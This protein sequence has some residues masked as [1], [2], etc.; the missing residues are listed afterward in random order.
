MKPVFVLGTGRCG[1]TLVHEVLVRHPEIGFISNLDDNLRMLNLKGRW[2]GP[3]YRRI[4]PRLTQKGRPRFA[5]SEGYRLL[6]RHVAP[7]FAHAFRD[8]HAED[9]TPWLARRFREFFEERAR[10][11]GTP[12]FLHKFTGWPRSGFI[13]EILPGAR[14][15]HVVRDG[16]AVVNSYLQ[17]PWWL[18]YRGPWAWQIGPLPDAYAAEWEEAGRSFVLL[19]ALGWKIFMDAFERARARVPAGDWL[20][21]RFEDFLADP[22]AHARQMLDFMGLEWT[23]A[24]ETG[25]LRFSF[26]RSRGLAYRDELGARQLQLVE[27][28]L[29]GHL[30][31][32]GYPLESADREEA[33]PELQALG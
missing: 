13:R 7:L 21:V 25:F 19:A 3:I 18:G 6:D 16:R 15:I 4:P 31:R 14:F 23:E 10:V 27:K 1:S 29:A 17:M 28:S 24:F 12:V 8:L 11:Q 20:D 22:R 26:H 32:W 33:R 9:A 2:N 30:R 5:P